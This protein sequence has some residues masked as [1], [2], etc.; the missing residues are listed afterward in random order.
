MEYRWLYKIYTNRLLE[1]Y[2]DKFDVAP[3]VELTLAELQ[4]DFKDYEDCFD[5]IDEFCKKIHGGYIEGD[6]VM[7]TINYDGEWSYCK[8]VNTYDYN[9]INSNVL[10]DQIRSIIDFD[11]KLHKK[12]RDESEEEWANKVKMLLSDSN[13]D[14][15]LFVTLVEYF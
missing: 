6:N 5:N 11:K 8:V 9:N 13:N 10:P 1:K 7:S 14:K 2:N 4:E 15:N 12:K 3:Y